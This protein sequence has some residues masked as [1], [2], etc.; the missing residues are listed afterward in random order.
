[1]L[2]I[3]IAVSQATV[4]KYMVR[5]QKPPCKHGEPF[6]H[7]KDLMQTSSLSDDYI[8]TPIRHCDSRPWPPTSESFHSDANPTA[9]WT[10]RQLLAAFRRN[11]APRHLLRW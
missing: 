8:P 1:L 4:A 7:A 9:K 5:H 10:A 3:K 2:K 6:N 11:H